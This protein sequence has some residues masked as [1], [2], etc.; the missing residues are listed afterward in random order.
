MNTNDYKNFC[1]AWDTA[2]ELSANG[3]PLSEGAMNMLFEDLQNYSLA[4]IIQAL[5][6]FR[7]NDKFAPTVAD[8]VHILTPQSMRHIGADEAWAIAKDAMN[9][10]NCVCTTDEIIAAMDIAY[11]LYIDDDETAARMAFRDAYNRIVKTAKNPVWFVSVGNNKAQAESVALK[12]IAL[13]RL[14]KGTD[15]KYRI[16]ATTTT[17]QKLIEGYVAKVDIRKD[18]MSVIK[19]MLKPDPKPRIVFEE[20][21]LTDEQYNALPWYLREGGEQQEIKQLISL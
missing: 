17:V 5:R 4:D 16:E 13:G 21:H 14:P 9:Q 15:A 7:L 10:D 20:D 11:D 6:I 12:A 1:E 8:I 18:S 2:H 19:A 3:K